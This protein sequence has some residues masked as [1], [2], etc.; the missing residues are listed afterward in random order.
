ME[1]SKISWTDHTWN[2][3]VGCSHVSQECDHCYADFLVTNRMGRDFTQPWRTKTWRDPFRWNA[4]ALELEKQLG[5]R[6]RVFCASLTDFFLKEA[7]PWRSEAWEVIR[8]CTNL[9]FLIL[10]KRPARI[11]RHLPADWGTGYRNVWLGT[12]CGVRSSYPRVDVLRH[13][14]ARVRFVSGEPLLESLADV[15]LTGIHWMIAGGKSG[16]KF[17]P[18]EERWAVELRDLCRKALSM[19]NRSTAQRATGNERNANSLSSKP[20]PIIGHGS[21]SSLSGASET[22]AFRTPKRVR[23]CSASKP[24][25]AAGLYIPASF[26]AWTGGE[27][28]SASR[29]ISE[30]HRHGL[31]KYRRL[32]KLR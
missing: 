2:P 14:P 7:D 6:V 22:G 9:D 23:V 1:Y 31:K 21:S 17:R 25:M 18:M 30:F 8:R 26:C 16:S 13:I 27:L 5:R 11:L 19:K 24:L 4:K 12:T 3:W 28:R 10:T 32:M 15:N 29:F 20:R